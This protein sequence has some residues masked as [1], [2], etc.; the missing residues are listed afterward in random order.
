M[1]TLFLRIWIWRALFINRGKLPKESTIENPKLTYEGFSGAFI[2]EDEGLWEAR[3]P[4]NEAFKYVLTHR[5]TLVVGP[6]NK[7]SALHSKKFDR[8]VYK[9]A[10][11]YFPDWIG[12]DESRCSYNPEVAD[13]MMRIIKVADWRMEK[14]FDEA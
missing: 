8:R 5:M 4:L 10:K 1:K 14:M 6:E 11:R 3:Y 12:F 2:W 7:V 9:M 13:R